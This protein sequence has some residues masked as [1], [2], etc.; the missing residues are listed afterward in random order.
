MGLK[1]IARSIRSKQSRR[2]PE[3][4]SKNPYKRKEK[5][6]KKRN[7]SFEKKQELKRLIKLYEEK[8][9]AKS[10][11]PKAAIVIQKWV[12]GY[13]QR[14]EYQIMK[15]NFKKIRKLRRFLSYGYKKVK[16]RFIKNLIF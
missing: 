13:L 5:E 1:V 3:Q 16:L 9:K 15:Q 8:Q 4:S 7:D 14:K 11:K 2:D 10:V 6:R 12:R